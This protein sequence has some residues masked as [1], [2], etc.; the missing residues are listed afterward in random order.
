MLEH[1]VAICLSI[2]TV[3][4][5]SIAY[6]ASLPQDAIYESFERVGG[7]ILQWT[8]IHRLVQDGYAKVCAIFNMKRL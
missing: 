8:P 3:F 6:T 5:M 2:I 4:I 1:S 7:A